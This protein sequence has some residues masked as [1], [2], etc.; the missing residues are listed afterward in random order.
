VAQGRFSSCPLL[1][2]AARLTRAGI[3]DHNQRCFHLLAPQ[4]KDDKRAMKW[5]TRE[6]NRGIGIATGPGGMSIDWD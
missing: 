3:Q 5:L 6:A 4:L 1:F 2:C